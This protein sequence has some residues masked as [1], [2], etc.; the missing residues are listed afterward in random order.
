MK[1]KEKQIYISKIDLNMEN[2]EIQKPFKPMIRLST[3]HYVNG[4]LK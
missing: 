2:N 4:Q 1:L 3:P